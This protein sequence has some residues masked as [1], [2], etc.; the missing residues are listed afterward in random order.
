MS[1]RK[2]VANLTN[3]FRLVGHRSNVRWSSNQNF[4]FF[5][6]FY[7]FCVFVSLIVLIYSFV[8][9][10]S[11][12]FLLLFFICHSTFFYLF[13][14]FLFIYSSIFFIIFPQHHYHN[15]LPLSLSKFNKRIFI[16]HK[17]QKKIY[18]QISKRKK[19]G[20]GREWDPN[21]TFSG[22]FYFYDNFLSYF[23]NFRINFAQRFCFIQFSIQKHVITVFF[24]FN[25]FHF[26]LFF[27]LKRSID[28]WI[29]Q[30]FC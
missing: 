30:S 20:W 25:I 8:S 9:Y 13:I 3:Y 27:S 4:P 19:R 6:V 23:F 28:R 1:N 29:D 10:P 21:T 14:C 11:R 17:K 18:F 2:K 5:L 12:I 26:F 16:V 24:S 22:H 7:F 15:F